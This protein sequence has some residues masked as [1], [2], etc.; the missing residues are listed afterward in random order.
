MKMM[1]YLVFLSLLIIFAGCSGAPSG[2][3]PKQ[4]GSFAL[5]SGPGLGTDDTRPGTYY[6]EYLEGGDKL[7]ST[8]IA[9]Q[10]KMQKTILY[11]VTPH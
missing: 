3:F 2:A 1:K 7:S 9:E 4:V 6:S 10:S 5:V 8:E 11:S